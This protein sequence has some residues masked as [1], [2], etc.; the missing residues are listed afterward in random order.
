MSRSVWVAVAL[1]AVGLVDSA[2]AQAPAPPTTTPTP[3]AAAAVATPKSAPADGDRADK[4]SPPKVNTANTAQSN[5]PA[6]AKKPVAAAGQPNCTRLP[7]SDIQFTQEKTTEVARM[8]L[9]E[10]AQKVAT[11]R[12]WKSFRKSDETVSCEVYLYLGPL[13]TEYKC[14]VTATFCPG[15]AVSAT[16][17]AAPAAKP[18]TVA[19]TPAAAPAAVNLPAPAANA[20][21]T[22]AA[23]PKAAP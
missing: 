13:G 8:R 3:P 21:A 19:T 4:V 20:P 10:Y 9:G 5:K 12:G 2:H 11:Q 18:A 7:L 17:K 23:T 22:T 6:G 15:P 1:A 14:L 16:A